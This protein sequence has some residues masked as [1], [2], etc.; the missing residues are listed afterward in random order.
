MF[1][2]DKNRVD[3]IG[4]PEAI[5]C[6]G[7]HITLLIEIVKELYS[8]IDK[9][10]YLLTRLSQEKANVLKE[11]F[12]SIDYDQL[13]RTAFIRKTLQKREGS[14]VIVSGGT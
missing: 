5:Y 4:M 8:D 10:C 13:S 9:N 2:L 12:E 14:V 6:E 7:K 11:K 1:N 3:R